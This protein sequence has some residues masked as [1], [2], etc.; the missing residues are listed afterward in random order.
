MH[1]HWR[2][3]LQSSTVSLHPRSSSLTRVLARA[4]SGATGGF[5]RVGN[6]PGGGVLGDVAQGFD[7]GDV[8]SHERK[9]VVLLP[10]AKLRHA[11]EVFALGVLVGSLDEDVDIYQVDVGCTHVVAPPT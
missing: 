8:R 10:V 2:W 11:L 7:P 9:S 1:R 5:G 4:V 6:R 3:H